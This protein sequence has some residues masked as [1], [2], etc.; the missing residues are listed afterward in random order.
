MFV[1]GQKDI[2]SQCSRASLRLGV[3]SGIFPT[4]MMQDTVAF[5][6][7]SADS[8]VYS[9][10][11][12]VTSMGRLHYKQGLRSPCSQWCLQRS[13]EQDCEAAARL[14]REDRGSAHCPPWTPR[15]APQIWTF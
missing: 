3:R 13:V 7:P 5:V 2:T 10:R 8:A 11:V 15:S 6:R 14:S 4:P 1:K 9:D 12:E